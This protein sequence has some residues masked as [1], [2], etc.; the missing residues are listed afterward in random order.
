MSDFV[1]LHV[2]TSYSLLDGACQIEPLIKAAKAQG[3]TAMAITDHGVM[4]G[5]I[6][7]YRAAVAGGIKPIIGCEVYVAEGSRFDRKAEGPKTAA[8]HLVLL[9]EN[10]AGYSNLS[11]LVTAAHLE[12]FYYKPRID[13]EI[14]AQNSRGLIVLSSCLKSKISERLL[15]DD[16]A[17]ALRAAGEIADIAGKDNFFLELEDHNLPEQKKV[18]RGL[19]ELARQTGLPLV[20]TNDVHYLKKEHARAHEV[21]LCLQTGT[22]LSDSKRMRFGS[23]EFYLKSS[24]EMEKLFRDEPAALENTVQIAHRC[25]VEFRFGEVHFPKFTIPAAGDAKE[26]FLSLCYEGARRRYGIADP[27]APR[28]EREKNILRRL[29]YEVDVIRE[30]G[31]LGY[32]LVVWDFVR[33]AHEKK[34]PVGPGRG[35]GAGSVVS[36]VLGITA[37]DPL[38]YNLV[39]E[40]FLNPKRVSPP[41]FDID[42]CQLRRQEVIEYVREKYGNENVAQIITFGSLGAKTVIRDVGRV[43]QIPLSRCDRLAKMVPEVP[44]MTLEMALNL[45]PEFKKACANEPEARQIM[46]YACVLEGLFRHAGL[47]AA[48]VVISDLP[49]KQKIPLSRDKDG[50][51]ITQFSKDHVEALGLLKADFLGLTTLSVID[52]TVKLVAR[53]KQKALDMDNIPRQD[54]AAYALFQR[55]DT[56]GVFQL[57]SRGMRDL[58]RR[59]GLNRIEDLIAM[60][61]LYRPGPMNMLDKYVESKTGKTKITYDDPRLEPI[62]AETYGILLYQEQVQ[63]AAHVLAG[64]SL[65]DGDILR[66]AMSKKNAAEMEKQRQKFIAGCHKTSGIP[67][68]KAERIFNNIAKFAGYGFNKSHSTGYAII[69][70]QTA[71]LKA[72]YPEEFMAALLSSEIDGNTKKMPLFINEACALGIEILPPDINESSVRF[73]P[74]NKAIRFGLAGIKN[75]G[76][77]AAEALVRERESNGPF[78]SLHDICGR[79]DTKYVNRKVLETLVRCGA[80]DCFGGHRAQLFAAIDSA[81]SRA[82]AIQRDRQAGQSNLFAVFSASAPA[83]ASEKLPACEPWHDSVVFG[84][85]KELLGTY[86][87]GHP[88]SQYEKLLKTYCLTTLGTVAEL[89]DG[90][91]TRA[92]GLI[93]RLEKKS[94]KENKLYAR[95][96]LEDTEGTLEVIVLPQVLAEYEKALVEGSAVLACGRMARE[97]EAVKM[98]L[99]E[100]YPLA[101]APGL[102]AERLSIH[103]PMAAVNDQLLQQIHAALKKQPG[104]TPVIFCLQSQQG[105]EIFLSTS[106]EFNVHAD[107]HLV[108]ELEKIV[109]EN[110]VYVSVSSKPCRKAESSRRSNG[111]RR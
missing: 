35:S 33:F 90:T 66:R 2:H 29:H 67:P 61:A 111:W 40:R 105:E 8:D 70:Y 51:I 7:F 36:Y 17:G 1:H 103:L 82:A 55:G 79:M 104:H 31:F 92:G 88:L 77:G 43:L 30:T 53:T 14:L 73:M 78:K 49:L 50:Q 108:N 10:A 27:H 87:S 6:E 71:Y 75:I 85:E 38:R 95:F 39:F 110:S 96:Q 21:L 52:E 89:D 44:D 4:Y 5:I 100:I 97:E 19:I 23:D 11:K 37:V 63:Q 46:Q 28:D 9:A 15:A 98:F 99:Q 26:F 25:N 20:A 68:K 106:P 64:F 65:G 91:L 102:F 24:P 13:L 93:A 58:V 57:E 83:G 56:V 54:P 22:F 69:A 62:L 80:C 76:E 47:H 32:F 81:I 109:G 107:E 59:I 101:E 12:G 74:L 34:I 94:T 3:Q 60:I 72:N 41:D 16:H 48:G 18:N 86:L 84:A 45:S 42:F